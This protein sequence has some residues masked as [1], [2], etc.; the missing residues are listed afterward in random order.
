M[1]DQRQP[2]IVVGVSGSRASVA[3]LRWAADEAERRPAGL[4]VVRSWDPQYRAPYAALDGL[5]TADQQRAV[6]RQDLA[7]ALCATFGSPA[8][9]GVAAELVKGVAERTLVDL[10]AGAD[11]LVLGA[12]SRPALSGC[13]AGPV[14]RACLSGA[15]C[16]V[17]VVGTQACSDYDRPSASHPAALRPLAGEALAQPS[18]AA[19]AG[20]GAGYAIVGQ[21]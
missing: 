3:A 14:I 10:S 12:T 4:R 8:P 11:L 18:A 15:H 16:P 6:A 9:I 20:G 1:N 2:T 13:S 19:P 17:V 5:L 21:R 7:A